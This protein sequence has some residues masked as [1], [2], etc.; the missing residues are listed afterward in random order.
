MTA[1]VG[2]DASGVVEYLFT[3]TSGNP[4]GRVVVGSIPRILPLAG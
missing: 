3:E 4:V 2:S 1:T